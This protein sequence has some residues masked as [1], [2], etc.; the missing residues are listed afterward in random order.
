MVKL[1]DTKRDA[2]LPSKRM[3]SL[4]GAVDFFNSIGV[5][6]AMVVGMGVGM[7]GDCNA[8]GSISDSEGGKIFLT[9]DKVVGICVD[10]SPVGSKV[11]CDL[12]SGSPKISKIF[13]KF[14]IRSSL[15]VN[16]IDEQSGS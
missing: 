9:G 11:G 8:E 14:S 6:V 5:V 15:D 13:T 4:V 2:K 12:V 7:G 16:S 10:G 1:E 3:S